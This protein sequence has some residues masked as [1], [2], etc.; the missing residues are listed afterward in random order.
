MIPK[1]IHYI[2][3][4]RNKPS[5]LMLNCIASWKKYC[6]DYEIIEWNEDNF[7]INS[8]QYVKEAYNS[9]QWA[10]ASDC[11]RMCI[12]HN[13]GGVYLD[14]DVEL[15]KPIDELLDAQIVA[16]EKGG[17]VAPGLI[18]A[19]NAGDDLCKIMIEEYSSENFILDNGLLNQ[20]TIC[21]RFTDLMKKNGLITDGS[22]QENIAGYNVYPEEYFCPLSY[23]DGKLLLTENTYAIHHYA[24]SW[25]TPW[26]KFKNRI[27]RFIGKER[28]EKMLKLIKEK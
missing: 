25:H 4:G 13:E 2:W 24:A 5:Q 18:M 27:I 26:R 10:F 1:K 9:K 7:D 19:V 17:R 14:T 11:I 20:T 8:I 6:P 23:D 22:Y 28:V 16:F 12:L 21:Q 15:L 3:L